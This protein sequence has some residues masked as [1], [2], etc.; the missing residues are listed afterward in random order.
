MLG[1]ATAIRKGKKM[2]KDKPGNAYCAYCGKTMPEELTDKEQL[3]FIARHIWE[4]R[5]HPLE[6][7]L[8]LVDLHRD[9]ALEDG[10]HVE[11]WHQ[12]KEEIDGV[13]RTFIEVAEK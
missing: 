4:C 5:K 3:A 2:S 11:H 9:G 7:V 1:F 8:M 13:R 6:R 12:L 10:A